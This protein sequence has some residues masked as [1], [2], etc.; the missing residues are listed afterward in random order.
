MCG[1]DWTGDDPM[2]ESTFL[3]CQGVGC[4]TERKLW[5]LGARTWSEFLE[6]ADDL[7]VS[8]SMR[9][10]LRQTVAESTLRLEAGD[11]AWF[12][13]M[14]PQRE[15]WRAL[16]VFR[17][18]IAYLDIETTGGVEP[19]DL[20][21]VGIYDGRELRQYVRGRNL[22]EFP[23]AIADRALLVTFFGTGF[24]L[25]FLRRAFGMEFP[26]LHIDLCFL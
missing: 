1:L 18:R 22:H 21:V 14:L 15:H 17:D 12:A 2:L 16:P 25:P 6:T 24:D 4:K 10:R 9:L 8:G 7:R 19:H 26:Q 23:K 13:R 5:E 3:H 11:Y 20:T